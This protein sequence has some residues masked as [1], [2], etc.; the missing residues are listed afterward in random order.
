MISRALQDEAFLGR[1]LAAPREA[2]RELGVS[3]EETEATTLQALS[4]EEFRA[5]AADYLATT[6]PSRRRAAC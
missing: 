2:A 5:F 4:P 3:L 1:L 6:D